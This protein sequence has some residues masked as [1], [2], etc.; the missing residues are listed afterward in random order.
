M[1]NVERERK[2]REEY[3]G[4]GWYESVTERSNFQNSCRDYL[5]VHASVILFVLLFACRGH[6]SRMGDPCRMHA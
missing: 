3:V 6:Y 2:V 1:M 5:Q 4:K